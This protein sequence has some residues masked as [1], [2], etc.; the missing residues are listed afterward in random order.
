MPLPNEIQSA[1]LGYDRNKGFWRRLF[2]DQAAI[3]ALRRLSDTE[4]TNFSKVYRCFIEHLP[5]PT[6]ASYRVFQALLNHLNQIDFHLLPEIMNVLHSA[7]LLKNNANLDRLQNLPSEFGVLALLLNRLSDKQLLTQQNFNRL[8]QYH[9]EPKKLV[10]IFGA[11]NTLDDA[12]C[13]TQENFSNLSKLLFELDKKQLL[14]KENTGQL[15]LL[16]SNSIH[17]LACLLKRLN[18]HLLLTQENLDK[19]TQYFKTPK[20]ISVISRAADTLG[21]AD[22]LTHDHFNSLLEVPMC[23]ENM[24]SALLILSSTSL[25]TSANREKLHHPYN[26]FLLSNEAHFLA[27]RP[28]LPYLLTLPTVLERQSVLD[29]FIKL[30]QQENP[31]K[32]IQYT[33]KGLLAY[34]PLTHH[35]VKQSHTQNQ[36]FPDPAPLNFLENDNLS[37]TAHLNLTELQ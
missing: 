6:Q 29:Q 5:T 24:V 33:M 21:D 2:G 28:L 15:A 17:V 23:A 4:Q 34:K 25:L 30:A 18:T 3:R 7:K 12:G 27:W 31:A 32:K 9:E 1:L 19:I 36:F 26:R 10:I 14:T 11:I 20:T 13:L 8:T 35:S 22:C 37:N 16:P